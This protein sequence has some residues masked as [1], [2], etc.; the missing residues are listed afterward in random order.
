MGT[1][2]SAE[3]YIREHGK[4]FERFRTWED[5]QKAKEKSLLKESTPCGYSN[6]FYI[7]EKSSIWWVYSDS[8]DGGIW[9]PNGLLITG[10][11]ISYNENIA[12]IIYGLIKEERAKTIAKNPYANIK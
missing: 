1:R 8:S 5:V 11:K 7:V 2:K 3:H 6:W 9:S 10:Y 4:K 12:S